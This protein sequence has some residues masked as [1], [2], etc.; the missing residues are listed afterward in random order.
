MQMEPIN[1][2]NFHREM[3]KKTIHGDSMETR[4][5]GMF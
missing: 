2:V 4:I 1:D 5:G 3:K